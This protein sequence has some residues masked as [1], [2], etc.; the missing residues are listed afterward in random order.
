MPIQRS[1][2]AGAVS[3]VLLLAGAVGFGVGLPELTGDEQASTAELPTLPDRLDDDVVALSAVTPE[4]AKAQTEQDVA[5]IEAFAE[6]VEASDAD[7]ADHL[8]ELYDDATVRSYISLASM[9]PQQSQSL[10][11]LG[12]TVVPGEAG[13]VIPRGPFEIEGQ[14]THY[15]LQTVDGHRCAVSWSEQVDPTTGAPVEGGGVNAASYQVECRAERDGLAYSVFSNGFDEKTVA[16]YLDR[17]LSA[18]GSED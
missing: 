10:R 1:T 5:D 12:V 2:V 18:T 9:D 6:Q 4:Q 15:K 17:V 7:A 16:G 14:G 8:T 3:G 13:L 11:T